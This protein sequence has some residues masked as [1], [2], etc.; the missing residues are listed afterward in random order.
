MCA[1]RTQNGVSQLNIGKEEHGYMTGSLVVIPDL[2]IDITS[3]T[4]RLRQ[5]LSSEK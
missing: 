1:K 5:L 3:S 2:F 4:S